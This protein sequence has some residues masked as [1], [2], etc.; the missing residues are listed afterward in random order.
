MPVDITTILRPDYLSRLQGRESTIV[1]G[2]ARSQVDG[3]TAH[4]VHEVRAGDPPRGPPPGTTD[5]PTGCPPASRAR[6][7]ALGRAECRE[8][9]AH[10]EAQRRSPPR[11]SP[12]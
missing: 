3:C 4:A 9:R 6:G 8:A 11:P 7:L 12:P 10:R 5:P 1:P 2:C